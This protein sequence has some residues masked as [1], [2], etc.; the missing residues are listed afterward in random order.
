MAELQ[1][2]LW[3]PESAG[4]CFTVIVNWESLITRVSPRSP[5]RQAYSE[6]MSLSLFT[7]P[8][9]RPGC[10]SWFCRELCGFPNAGR[11]SDLGTDIEVAA[12]AFV[13]STRFRAARNVA[14]VASEVC[15]ACEAAV[16]FV[17]KKFS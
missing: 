5:A 6:H 12:G 16:G 9:T 14:F 17:V 8:K 11:D 3:S 2:C 7:A 10:R 4:R 15:I 13:A 1:D